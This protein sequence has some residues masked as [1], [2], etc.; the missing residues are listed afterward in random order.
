MFNID[1]V[2]YEPIDVDDWDTR[3]H[4]T[5]EAG[6]YPLI[7]PLYECLMFSAECCLLYAPNE[8]PDIWW[9]ILTTHLIE[10]EHRMGCTFHQSPT[11]DDLDLFVSIT[12]CEDTIHMQCEFFSWIEEQF[13]DRENDDSRD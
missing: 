10:L 8:S 6:Y 7:T 3:G 5:R 9:G 1:V 2:E 11:Q 12:E 4:Y 13:P